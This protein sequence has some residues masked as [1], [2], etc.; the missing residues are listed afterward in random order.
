MGFFQ[1]LFSFGKKAELEEVRLA[2][3][4]NWID[5]KISERFGNFN[6][7]IMAL[8]SDI[9]SKKDDLKT[10]MTELEKAQLMNPNIPLKAK[11]VM[12]GNRG[13][14]IRKLGYFL[15]QLSFPDEKAYENILD[16]STNFSSSLNEFGKN[17]SKNFYVL[18]EF[19]ATDVKKIAQNIR[20]FELIVDDLRKQ[21]ERGPIGFGRI[22]G[23]LKNIK[24]KIELKKELNEKIKAI[25]SEIENI[26]N[27]IKNTGEELK[28]KEENNEFKSYKALEN[29]KGSILIKIKEHKAN[30]LNIFGA[31]E[32]ALKKYERMSVDEAV[33]HGYL[34]DPINTLI[35]D[36][37]FGVLELLGRLE[38][39]I[40]SLD[41]KEDKKKRTLELIKKLDRDSFEKFLIGLED[42]E[43]S[44]KMFEEK[45][46][47]VTIIKEHA[48]LKDN[49][50]EFQ[51]ELQKL[52]KE[53]SLIKEKEQDIDIGGFKNYLEKEIKRVVGEDVRVVHEL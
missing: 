17:T 9:K 28:A 1:R 6:N 16:F 13:A 50:N 12:E 14:Y 36:K 43:N 29:E 34:V 5:Q 41:L 45:I 51:Y 8:F 39:N 40:D 20:E 46:K 27:K 47:A 18:N 7:S 42:L 26:K 19:F 33:V 3:A 21:V 22:K 53:H 4:E 38:E 15:E 30:F 2:E 24:E 52:Q 31:F 35:N 49:L 25:E 10:N 11:E 44:A 37:E 23:E 48:E 32:K